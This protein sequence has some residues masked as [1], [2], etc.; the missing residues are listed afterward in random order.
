MKAAAIRLLRAALL[1]FTALQQ[2]TI[3]RAHDEQNQQQ[4]QKVTFVNERPDES[5]DLFWEN[6]SNGDRK[7]EGTIEPRGG[8]IRVD[9]FIGH[10][11]I[12]YVT[13]SLYFVDTL[14]IMISHLNDISHAMVSITLP[15]LQKY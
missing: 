9:S 14:D 2:V 3:V 8:F 15:P 5:I 11:K 7:L 13:S 4:Q 10:G 6:H 1:I 12:M